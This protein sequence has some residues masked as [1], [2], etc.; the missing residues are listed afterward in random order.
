MASY[1]H[2]V[3]CLPCKRK[4]RTV[5]VWGFRGEV[6]ANQSTILKTVMVMFF[7]FNCQKV[8]ALTWREISPIYCSPK[9]IDAPVTVSNPHKCPGVSWRKE[10]QPMEI[11]FG[12]RSPNG[13]KKG[14]GKH[15][16]SPYSSCVVIHVSRR[17]GSQIWLKTAT[18]T[19]CSQLKYPL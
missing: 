4:R 3:S 2:S 16:T 18:L 9:S 8:A 10:F 13:K 14:E 1:K 6:Q 11:Y 17:L 12:K 15:D 5:P 7:K 19:Q